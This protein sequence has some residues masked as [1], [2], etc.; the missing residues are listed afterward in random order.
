MRAH[1]LTP[2]HYQARFLAFDPI[3][4]SGKVG[5][6]E[7]SMRVRA[8]V[9]S[10]YLN[11]VPWL[12]IVLTT[13]AATFWSVAYTS[14]LSSLQSNRSFLLLLWAPHLPPE[15]L[16]LF[17]FERPVQMSHFHFQGSTQP[18]PYLHLCSHFLLYSLF[19]QVYTYNPA[20]MLPML[21]GESLPPE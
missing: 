12:S 18:Y 1:F 4:T 11:S 14:Q 19:R 6:G 7:Q 15:I 5:N 16:S 17:S 8:L 3:Y 10:H 13:A 9:I 2:G 20:P 21:T